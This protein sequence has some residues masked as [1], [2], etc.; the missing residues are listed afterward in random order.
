M[1]PPVRAFW[2]QIGIAV[3][4]LLA[5]GGIAFSVRRTA[6]GMSPAALLP[7]E[8]TVA[9]LVPHKPDD[10]AFFARWLP[11]Q[12]PLPTIE[13]GSTLAIVR[14]ANRGGWIL[15]RPSPSGQGEPF[16]MTASDPSLLGLLGQDDAT[17]ADDDGFRALHADLPPDAGWAYVG[18]RESAL[19]DG[20]LAGGPA[21]LT[22]ETDRVTLRV[23]DRIDGSAATTAL[24]EPAGD[25]PIFSAWIADWEDMAQHLEGL[26]GEQASL[27]TAT[28]A[29]SLLSPLFGPDVSLRHDVLP[30]IDAGGEVRLE[31]ISGT[32]LFTLAGTAGSAD[33]ASEG[34]E[35]L[36]ASFRTSAGGSRRERRDFEGGFKMD[37][38]R[39]DDSAVDERRVELEGWDVLEQSRPGGPK[40]ATAISGKRFVIANDLDAAITGAS[41]SPIDTVGG[42]IGFSDGRVAGG[43]ID[44]ASLRRLADNLFPDGPELPFEAVFGERGV[45]WSLDDDGRRL[46]LELQAAAAR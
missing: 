17:L 13:A 40:L 16:V 43:T 38:L 20:W 33:E 31:T 19:L 1:I 28:M 37:W 21:V 23:P 2:K 26:A 11:T 32:T 14:H 9:L 46:T 5:A 29:Q 6:D 18:R 22:V 3:A 10:V 25:R 7:V 36:R 12:A 34:I 30:M 41:G 45:S 44:P 8:K 15:F 35:R 24:R 27:L 42:G 4:A 39:A